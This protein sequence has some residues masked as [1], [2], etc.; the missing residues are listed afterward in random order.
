MAQALQEAAKI[1]ERAC[2]G[3]A[4]YGANLYLNAYRA[5]GLQF[6]IASEKDKTKEMMI[7]M[8]APP[9]DLIKPALTSE[10]KASREAAVQ[11]QKEKQEAYERANAIR[12]QEFWEQARKFEE[13]EAKIKAH[14]RSA[15]VITE[16]LIE[17]KPEEFINGVNRAIQDAWKKVNPVHAGGSRKGQTIAMPVAFHE[18]GVLFF[19]SPDLKNPMKPGNPLWKR[20]RD[21]LITLWANEG[22]KSA[23]EDMHKVLEFFW[24]GWKLAHPGMDEG[25]YIWNNKKS[26]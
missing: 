3:H 12:Q 26:A 20:D 13:H 7:T 8:K 2:P 4:I 25:R 24:K 18:D 11:K 5:D 1:Y 14:L 22:W 6:G 17:W 19:A 16:H 10:A 9:G 23:Q 21:K 15:N